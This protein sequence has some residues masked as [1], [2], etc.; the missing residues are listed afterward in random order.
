MPP[1][2]ALVETTLGNYEKTATAF[3]SSFH[4]VRAADLSEQ[5]AQRFRQ[6]RSTSAWQSSPMP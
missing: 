3:R 6:V 4:G 5:F 1:A 2:C